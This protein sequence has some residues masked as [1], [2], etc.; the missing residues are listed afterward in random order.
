MEKIKEEIVEAKELSP[1]PITKETEIISREFASGFSLNGDY[2]KNLPK[3]KFKVLGYKTVLIDD[4]ENKNAKKEKLVL[5]VELNDDKVPIE[6]YP[7]KTSQQTIIAKKG[8][9]YKNWVGFEGEFETFEQRVG[10]DMKNV[11]YIKK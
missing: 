1:S 5:I 11:I 8:Y 7:N 2:V 9:A 10:K 3:K 6:Y 4:L